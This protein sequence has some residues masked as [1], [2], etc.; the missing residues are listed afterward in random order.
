MQVQVK[1]TQNTNSMSIQ[2]RQAVIYAQDSANSSAVKI[3][4]HKLLSAN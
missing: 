3:T 2:A 1:G 4:H